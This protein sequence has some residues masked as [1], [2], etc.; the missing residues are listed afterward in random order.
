MPPP[1][2]TSG[3][4]NM[5]SEDEAKRLSRLLKNCESRTFKDNGHTFAGYKAGIDWA[6][7]CST[8]RQ[9][10]DV[11]INTEDGINLLTVIKAT[12]KYGRSRSLDFVTDFVLQVCKNTK[13]ILIKLPVVCWCWCWIK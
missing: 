4:D 1:T 7:W 12:N 10:C 8:V 13:L 11:P 9:G 3:K 6:S 5:P 2:T